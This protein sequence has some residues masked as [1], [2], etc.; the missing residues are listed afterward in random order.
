[1]RGSLAAACAAVL[2]G[3][4]PAGVLPFASVAAAAVCVDQSAQRAEV[5]TPRP[6]AQRSAQP[7]DLSAQAVEARVPSIFRS[8]SG[9]APS[10]APPARA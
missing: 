1:M 2:V 9:P 3:L 4:S 7:R 10:Q 6:A 8:P 5:N